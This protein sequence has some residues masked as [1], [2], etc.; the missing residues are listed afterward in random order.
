MILWN[1]L[2][3]ATST[4]TNGSGRLP[5]IAKALAPAVQI[6]MNRL[7]QG[8]EFL[9]NCST[10]LVAIGVF[11]EVFEIIHELR[12]KVGRFKLHRPPMAKWMVWAGLAGW[13]MIVVGVV[14]ELVFE[15]A[16][17]TW[18]EQ[19]E[20]LSNGLVI[21]AQLTAA[22]ATKQAGDAKA[23]AYDA[24]I[25]AQNAKDNSGQ[26]KVLSRE[27]STDAESAKAGM[28]EARKLADDAEDT[29]KRI[30]T[31][32]SL[33][34]PQL[35]TNMLRQ[36]PGTKYTFV[37]V[38]Q[39]AESANFVFALDDV[40][41]QAGWVREETPAAHGVSVLTLTPD[42]KAPFNVPFGLNEG[43]R[44]SIEYSGDRSKLK[45]TEYKDLPRY[46]QAAEVLN[47]NLAGFIEPFEPVTKGNVEPTLFAD[48]GSSTT[49]RLAIGSKP[50]K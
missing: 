3:S 49:V 39:D 27:A 5:E 2:W 47:S 44:I 40:F 7:R 34:M 6:A 22:D 48:P 35:L 38:F 18:N 46:V 23:S 17:S 25:D 8:D 15:G 41:Q 13:V 10:V 26:A 30:K 16:V 14:G 31:P 29:L 20:S 42:G 37:S 36:F 19:L 12:E 45:A 43:I 11:L 4:S 21:D 9:L 1:I 24:G 50:L 33:R 32:R 28:A